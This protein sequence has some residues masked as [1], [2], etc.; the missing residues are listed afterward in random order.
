MCSTGRFHLSW[1]RNKTHTRICL[2][3]WLW[4]YTNQLQFMFSFWKRNEIPLLT[5]TT[6]NAFGQNCLFQVH[7]C[8]PKSVMRLGSNTDL[9]F[10]SVLPWWGIQII[11]FSHFPYSKLDLGYMGVISPLYVFLFW[12]I[13]KSFKFWFCPFT[14]LHNIYISFKKTDISLLLWYNKMQWF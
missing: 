5:T 7:L 14:K 2:I 10:V 13:F 9:M 12:L 1:S 3:F 11:F 8:V 4:K 6:V